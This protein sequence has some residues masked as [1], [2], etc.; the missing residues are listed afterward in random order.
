MLVGHFAQEHLTNE[1]S[2]GDLSLAQQRYRGVET[3]R[4]NV[5]IKV[6]GAKKCLPLRHTPQRLHRGVHLFLRK[7][8]THTRVLDADLVD[9]LALTFA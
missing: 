6:E 2:L 1:T 8:S 3:K 9:G 4:N 7:S 5:R